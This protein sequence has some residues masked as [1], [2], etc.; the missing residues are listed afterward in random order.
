MLGYNNWNSCWRIQPQMKMGAVL[1]PQSVKKN[2]RK[3]RRKKSRRKGRKKRKRRK[4]ESINLPSPTR[5]Q[6]QTNWNLALSHLKAQMLW[7][8]GHFGGCLCSFHPPTRRK[9]PA[10]VPC[11]P[12][13]HSGQAHSSSGTSTGPPLLVSGVSSPVPGLCQAGGRDSRKLW[14]TLQGL[15]S[16]LEPQTLAWLLTSHCVWT[17]KA[18]YLF[19]KCYRGFA[20]VFF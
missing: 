6:T 2:T 1:V 20:F 10:W 19:L 14:G 7:S 3:E 4:N 16:W 12:A 13:S 5:A 8:E 18:H 15:P 17:V 9:T 11:L